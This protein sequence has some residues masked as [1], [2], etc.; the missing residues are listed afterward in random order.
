MGAT[1]AGLPPMNTIVSALTSLFLL[2]VAPAF[3]QTADLSRQEAVR[4]RG[5]DVMPF[6]M[7]ATTRTSSLRHQKAAFSAWS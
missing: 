6:D 7:N 3:G 1:T 4:E 2:A 5:A